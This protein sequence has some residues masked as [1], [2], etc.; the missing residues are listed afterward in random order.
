M[1]ADTSAM[2][3]RESLKPVKDC[4]QTG[5]VP[6]WVVPCL[7]RPD[8]RPVPGAHLTHLLLDQQMH[9][10]L[11][12]TCVHTARRLETM[13]AVHTEVPWRLDFRPGREQITLHWIRTWRGAASIDHPLAASMRVFDDPATGAT[14]QNRRTVLFMLEDV[15]PGDILEWCYTI[16][17]QP[18]LLPEH[19]SAMFTLPVGAPVGKFH[20]SVRFKP[21]RDLRWKASVPEW[22]PAKT[23]ENNE[24]CWI[25]TQENYA[26]AP[27]EQNAPE[28]HVAHP[29]IQIS[30][31]SDWAMV[32]QAFAVA[33]PEQPA[34][35]ALAE[36]VA[37]ITGDAA[38]LRRQ[39]D[40][41]IQLV[42][43]E[44]RHVE[45]AGDVDGGRPAPPEVVARR[46]YG[47]A[48]DLSFFLAH[49]L[50]Q[51]GAP[52]SIVLVNTN[53]GRALADLLPAPGL[54]NH[55]LVEYCADD[56]TRWVDVSRGM[57]GGASPRRCFRDY[58][59]GLVID[60]PCSDL[61]EPPQKCVEPSV[62]KL[63]ESFLLDTADGWSLLAVVVAARGS[64]ADAL[65]QELR[66]AGLE[67]MA[68][69]R[70]RH[71]AER[72]GQARRVKALEHRDDG[73]ANEFFLA[74]IFEVKGFLTLD[75]ATGWF[76]FDIN[77]DFLANTLRAPEGPRRAALG[78]PHP[79]ELIHLIELHSVS[80][81]IAA[82]Q[83]RSVESDYL[84]F[85]RMRETM[86]GHWTM[87]L[88]LSTLADAVPAESLHEHRTTLTE[89]RGQSGWSLLLPGGYAR[90]RPRGDFGKLPASWSPGA[91]APVARVQPAVVAPPP[92]VVRP[93]PVQPARVEV[94]LP[95]APIFP[96]KVSPLVTKPVEPAPIAMATA[97]NKEP[98]TSPT[99]VNLVLPP[100]VKVEPMAGLPVVNPAPVSAKIELA[101]V[102][103]KVKPAPASVKVEPTPVAV[104]AEPVAVTPAVVPAPMPQVRP[105]PPPV[106][107]SA[108]TQAPP[109]LP[110]SKPLPAA[111]TP[112]AAPKVA[113]AA[114]EMKPA[115]V[116]R[117]HRSK[118]PKPAHR[119][120]KRRRSRH[121][122][123]GRREIKRHI[124]S[125]CIFALVLI[126]IVCIV[127][128]SADHFGIFKQRPPT[129][130]QQNDPNFS[131]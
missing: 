2:Q 86:A 79:C 20:F 126:L 34:D 61:V 55:L 43:D 13:Q 74:E 12:Q 30:D 120:K 94:K 49:L 83:Q 42:Q 77:N 31:C 32:G 60:G 38:G 62:L 123:A 98:A 124:M 24:I 127:A 18:A 101:P 116:A 45:T 73:A 16:A 6:D 91:N 84:L 92:P 85:T 75:G 78:L 56:E 21:S 10:E 66:N 100:P 37:Q 90:P 106:E 22:Q 35:T 125:A 68:A 104:P 7:F 5:P 15:R 108:A 39:A 95:S 76:K 41:A 26:G 88:S 23:Q 36:I 52:A 115:P 53:F 121:T 122:K 33:W 11:R 47:D 27:Q 131:Q 96:V 29:W 109:E 44:F 14:S 50:N 51:L 64:Y 70:L 93:E 65:R 67:E 48:R 1:A 54:F 80:L 72:F 103:A 99:P 112:S 46:R 57:E 40:R 28:W 3:E 128:K 107:T 63:H 71:Y 129:L 82:V 17:S 19:C 8:F 110:P 25:W 59:A 81:P 4:I 119:E 89:I 105:P 9:A 97:E 58:G 117:R 130:P 113:G 118:A 69:K 114:V 87:K 102:A 111:T